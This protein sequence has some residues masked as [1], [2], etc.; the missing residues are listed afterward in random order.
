MPQSRKEEI[1]FTCMMAFGMVLCMSCYNSVWF[2]GFSGNWVALALHNLSREYWLALPVAY[3]IGTPISHRLTLRFWPWKQKYFPIGM[4]IFT[5]LVMV[6]LM[7][8][9]I[10]LLLF[11]IS[12][13]AVIIPAY[14]RN[15]LAAI[16]FQL[17]L[18]G[19]LVRFFFR[20]LVAERRQEVSAD[21]TA[22]E[23]SLE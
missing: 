20:K 8:T 2:V 9:L 1:I 3:F 22:Q 19:P 18:V 14:G 17:L 4:G 11:Q 15:Y 21:T 10:H 7:T 6:P 12:D 5:P 23:S 16:F 13:P